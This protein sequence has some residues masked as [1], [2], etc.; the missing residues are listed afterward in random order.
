MI[1]PLYGSLNKMQSVMATVLRAIKNFRA[2]AKKQPLT[3]GL[4]TTSEKEEARQMLVRSDQQK[5]FCKEIEAALDDEHVSP[6]GSYQWFDKKTQ[7]LRLC[8][9]VQSE[10]LEFDAQHPAFISPKGNLAK[11]L[12]RHAH[13]KTL[14]GGV[15]QIIQLIREKYWIPKL[16]RL[17]QSIIN[18]CP[19]C[20][21]YRNDFRKQLMAPLPRE[22][23]SPEK[24]FANCGVDYLGPVG[25]ALKYG[26]NP[27]VVKGYV[28]VFVCFATRAIHLELVSDATTPQFLQALRRMIARRGRVTNIWSDNGTNFCGANNF[29]RSIGNKQNE[30]AYQ[31]QN[32]MSITWHF[33]TPNAPHH[34]GIYEAAVKST[35]PHKGYRR[36]KPDVRGVCNTPRTSGGL[37]EFQAAYATV[38]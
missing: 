24:P 17:V 26:R 3:T 28:C 20:F 14:H 9:R 29:L 15:Q 25:L 5:E 30:W 16:R 12:I 8:G 35:K 22:R 19:T 34:G 36:Q 7:L 21:R 33:A 32:E 31:V 27:T 13:N 23:T 38:G 4:L 11:L 2:K 6:K 18:F 37:R 1:F 10:N